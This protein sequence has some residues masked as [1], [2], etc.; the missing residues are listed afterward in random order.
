LGQDSI[1]YFNRDHFL[2]PLKVKLA[3]GARR[4]MYNRVVELTR[5]E[6][7]TSILD[8]GT[9]PDLKLACNNFFERWYPHSNRLT[10]CSIEDCSNL[11]AQFPGLR[12][13]QLAGGTLPFA[14]RQF[15]VVLSFAVFRARWIE[16]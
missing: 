9:T 16:R 6:A 14:D 12:F 4:R 8:V 13:V 10:A 3:M 1:D 7:K 11:E 2:Q 15:D 5:A